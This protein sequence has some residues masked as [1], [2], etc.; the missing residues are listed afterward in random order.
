MW[1]YR[2]SADETKEKPEVKHACQNCHSE[3]NVFV[4]SNS[5]V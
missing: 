2:S 3:V 5:Q 4:T 1:S